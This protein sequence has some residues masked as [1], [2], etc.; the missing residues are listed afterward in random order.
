MLAEKGAETSEGVLA[1][2]SYHIIVVLKRQNR[3]KAKSQD[4]VSIR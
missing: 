1:Y 2:I 3:L 4:A